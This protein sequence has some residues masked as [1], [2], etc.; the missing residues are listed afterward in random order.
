MV[1]L[2]KVL[3]WKA[4][5][6]SGTAK[7]KSNRLQILLENLERLIKIHQWL[8]KEHFD[9]GYY[10]RNVWFLPQK[11]ENIDNLKGLEVELIYKWE[12]GSMLIFD[13]T[14]LHCSS[15][16]IEG[17]KIGIATFTKK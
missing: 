1:Q 5:V 2:S 3:N 7:K 8:I 9:I 12:V 16:I 14:H 17:N 10:L 15:S 6:K 11:N 13:R 4:I